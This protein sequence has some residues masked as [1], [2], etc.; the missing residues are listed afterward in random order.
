M[1]Y[2]TSFSLYQFIKVV[3]RLES[4][5]IF[6]PVCT[7]VLFY[8]LNRLHLSVVTCICCHGFAEDLNRMHP[9]NR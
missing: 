3:A 1:H 5:P 2:L 9:N 8:I 7:Q 4:R 6:F